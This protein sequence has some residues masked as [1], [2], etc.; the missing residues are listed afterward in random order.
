MARS[1][2]RQQ[3][4]TH[5]ADLHPRFTEIPSE[6]QRTDFWSLRATWTPDALRRTLQNDDPSSARLLER[7]LNGWQWDELSDAVS[8][9]VTSCLLTSFPDFLSIGHLVSVDQPAHVR[10][11]AY[12]V[13]CRADRYLSDAV[14]PVQQQY[15]PPATWRLRLN[16]AML[17]CYLQACSELAEGL[18]PLCDRTNPLRTSLRRDVVVAAH[19]AYEALRP[20]ANLW[21]AL[22]ADVIGAFVQLGPAADL[23][24]SPAHQH[25]CFELQ[26]QVS[27][28]AVLLD[29]NSAHSDPQVAEWWRWTRTYFEH[30][31]H[32]GFHLLHKPYL[33]RT[34]RAHL[35]RA[36][37]AFNPGVQSNLQV[38][39]K[40]DKGAPLGNRGPIIKDIPGVHRMMA[41]ELRFLDAVLAACR[42]SKA[43]PKHIPARPTYLC[44]PMHA[45]PAAKAMARA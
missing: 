11:W 36:C 27:V 19:T 21:R 20:A 2:R 13:C 39:D 33:V 12:D 37:A 17:M 35:R 41:D 6:A 25:R 40:L 29:D 18:L 5:V 26:R 3:H 23:I 28:E 16:V 45:A 31:V 30:R 22:P 15:I 8:A 43:S 24:A 9:S 34:W 4:A 10:N 32:Y 14:W 7:G 1:T 38:L 42:G 44:P